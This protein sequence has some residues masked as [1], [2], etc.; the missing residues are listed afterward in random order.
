M[1]FR[2][3]QYFMCVY[4]ELSITRAADKLHVVQPAVSMQLRRLEEEL[5]AQL[6]E[7]RARG[8]IPT[9]T[10]HTIYD[11][12]L[13]VMLD[14][15]LA[16]E[17]AIE[18]SRGMFGKLSIG[19]A[20]S[21]A[22]SVL[23]MTLSQYRASYPLVELHII[24]SDSGNL[25]R[26]VTTGEL[27]FAVV[28][29]MPRE[30]GIQSV[31]MMEE[32]LLLIRQKQGCI[33]PRGCI[34]F[35]QLANF[36]LILPNSPWGFRRAIDMVATDINLKLRPLL[37]INSPYAALDLVATNPSLAAILPVSSVANDWRRSFSIQRIGNPPVTRKLAYLHR[38]NAHLSLPAR[39][40][41]ARMK[42]E[43]ESK[44]KAS[45]QIFGNC[46]SHQ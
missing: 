32:D 40:F 42:S 25:L 1:D 3:V 20:L 37:E 22:N 43:L 45:E 18:R 46:P 39:E 6:F 14:F 38:A 44:K 36:D 19:I 13:P 17:R 11:L 9:A 35:P 27:D 16:G 23:G 7:R 26:M 29:L 4:E 15:R 21:V 31:V 30:K 8:L 10:A 12:Y 41:L 33:E 24:E 5:G 28:N 34:E 2:Q